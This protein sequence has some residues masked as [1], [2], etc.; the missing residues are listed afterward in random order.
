MANPLGLAGVGRGKNTTGCAQGSPEKIAFVI[1]VPVVTANE[2]GKHYVYRVER[3][4]VGSPNQVRP[5]PTPTGENT[6]P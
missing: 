2:E 4:N 3:K 6:A 5:G 1:P